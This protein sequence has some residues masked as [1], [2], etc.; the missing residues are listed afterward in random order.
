MIKKV[1]KD[2]I[3]RIVRKYNLQ[4]EGRSSSGTM[5]DIYYYKKKI[6]SGFV[7]YNNRKI[8]GWAISF[9]ENSHI[10]VLPK[11]RRKGIGT[12]IYQEVVLNNP[13]TYFE[14][15]DEVSDKFF[16]KNNAKII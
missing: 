8:Q 13:E 11:Y 1:F 15:W 5:D 3:K 2:R 16:E 6:D 4:T 12:K 10:Y 7:A 14:P 9:K